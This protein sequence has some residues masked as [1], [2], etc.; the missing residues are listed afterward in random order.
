DF[1]HGWRQIDDTLSDCSGTSTKYRPPGSLQVHLRDAGGLLFPV[2]LFHV[3]NP[4]SDDTSAPT[5]HL[6]GI[7]EEQ[8]PQRGSQSQA[9]SQ[10]NASSTGG[11]LNE[12]EGVSLTFDLMSPG[13]T[14]R[15]A[16]IRFA[17][18]A[19]D[20][21]GHLPCV[22]KWV[23]RSSWPTLRTWVQAQYNAVSAGKVMPQPELASVEMLSPSRPD[24]LLRVRRTLLT[25]LPDGRE[26][27]DEH[28]DAAVID[29][30][31]D[32][33]TGRDQQGG[34]IASSSCDQDSEEEDVLWAKLEM[35]HFKQLAG[36]SSSGSSQIPETSQLLKK[37]FRCS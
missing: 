33:G 25:I 27:D 6:I 11:Q 23:H 17:K 8:G 13:F 35:T 9:S 18:G 10:S 7:K 5:S 12:I 14:I 26:S 24:A 16:R 3:T 30:D 19:P 20:G 29:A 37:F 4:N 36:A 22:Q 31:S 2:D 21:A 28:D 15:E 32:G 1:I 34:K